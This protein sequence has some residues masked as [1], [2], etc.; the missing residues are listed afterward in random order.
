MLAAVHISSIYPAAHAANI[1]IDTSRSDVPIP[2]A[3][4][5]VLR[6]HASFAS[7]FSSYITGTILLRVIHGGLV[8]ELI[9]FATGSSTQFSF[10]SP[11]LPS[12]S[13]LLHQLSELRIFV[14][15]RSGSL[16]TLIFPVGDNVPLFD[17][18]PPMRLWCTEYLITTP[19]D[20]FEGPV[21]VKDIDCV[22]IG[23]RPGKFLRLDC[24]LDYSEFHFSRM[25]SVLRI[26]RCMARKSLSYQNIMGLLPGVR[27]R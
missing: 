3:D 22:F 4:H 6:D 24:G 1:P 11:I 10:P 17:T 13:I 12:P 19:A 27:V 5:D 15:T 7:S 25:R 16:F 18:T 8:L 2:T 26:F 20:Q 9:P 21:H 23:L 14:V